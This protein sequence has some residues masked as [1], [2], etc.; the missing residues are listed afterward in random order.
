MYIV[1]LNLQLPFMI[2]RA[3]EPY[4]EQDCLQ[5]MV[6]LNTSPFLGED[7]SQHSV[8]LSVSNSGKYTILVHK[9]I[10]FS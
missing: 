8:S 10:S 9:L 7:C 4:A 6:P 1:M 2:I 3:M 5:M